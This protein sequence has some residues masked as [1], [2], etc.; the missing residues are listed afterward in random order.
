M[1][2]ELDVLTQIKEPLL[3]TKEENFESEKMLCIS[4]KV[5]SR[6]G[7]FGSFNLHKPSTLLMCKST[8]ISKADVR[9]L[10][11]LEQTSQVYETEGK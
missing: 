10:F 8:A 7:A 5:I 9:H 4:Q 3:K 6:T 11:L 2:S 1:F